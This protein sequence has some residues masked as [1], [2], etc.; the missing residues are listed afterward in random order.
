MPPTRRPGARDDAPAFG[1]VLH[2]G[3]FGFSVSVRASPFAIDVLGWSRRTV[4]QPYRLRGRIWRFGR[5]SWLRLN[6]RSPL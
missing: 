3:R 1:F 5:F 2:A 4:P 6:E